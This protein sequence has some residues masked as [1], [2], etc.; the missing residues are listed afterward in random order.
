MKNR[1]RKKK[2]L[3]K[4]LAPAIDMQSDRVKKAIAACMVAKEL[5]VRDWLVTELYLPAGVD[6]DTVRAFYQDRVTFIGHEAMTYVVVDQG[7][8]AQK[9]VGSY[10]TTPNIRQ[11]GKDIVV[12]W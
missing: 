3:L 4:K 7:K 11:V 10:P 5:E 9:L 1:T 2:R 12:E 6:E 8:P